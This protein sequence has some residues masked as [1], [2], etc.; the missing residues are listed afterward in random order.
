M[1][2]HLLLLASLLVACG[3][4][5]GGSSSGSGSG[6]G[7][8]GSATSGSSGSSGSLCACPESACGT[9][10]VDLANDP[11]NCGGCGIQCTGPC[12]GTQCLNGT[13]QPP[14]YW[15]CSTGGTGSGSGS[16]TGSSSG[17]G[18]TSSG[19]TTGAGCTHACQS[20]A[21]CAAG[22]TCQPPPFP[23]S[24]TSGGGGYTCQ[25]CEPPG[26]VCNGQ[27][28]HGDQVDNCGACGNACGP[29]QA[30]VHGQCVCKTHDDG[31]GGGCTC[32]NG[33]SLCGDTCS[34]LQ[35]DSAHCGDCQ[36]ACAANQRCVSG[37]CAPPD[38]GA[39]LD[40]FTSEVLQVGLNAPSALLVDVNGD[41]RADLVA[42]S[43]YSRLG[44]GGF[45]PGQL[46]VALSVD[47]GLGSF[48]DLTASTESIAAGDLDGD[49]KV[50]LVA[51]D[52]TNQQLL[53]FF[54]D[55]AGGF[56]PGAS[57]PLPS[58]PEVVRIADFNGDGRPDLFVEGLNYGS[59]SGWPFE[60]EVV[61][62][63][64]S[65]AFGTAVSTQDAVALASVYRGQDGFVGDLNGD[66]KADVAATSGLYLGNGDG[67]FQPPMSLGAGVVTTGADLDGDGLTD[68][69]LVGG[70]D[71]ADG[72]TV[73]ALRVRRGYGDG[74]F[75][76]SEVYA[77]PALPQLATAGRF[78]GG[79]LPDLALVYSG[80]YR[81]ENDALLLLRNDGTGHFALDLQRYDLG[82]AGYPAQG[83]AGDLD[84]NGRDDLAIAQAY[85]GQVVLLRAR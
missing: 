48:L 50:D 5:G 15:N 59:T 34:D 57:V 32:T 36:T 27:C 83:S 80:Y 64:R 73:D 25:P 2:L 1:R 10:C 16:G 71:L 35:T 19:G 14:P 76:P 9:R 21:D 24:T 4:G 39:R 37:R 13:C 55:G 53:L 65:G 28:V 46:R 78:T 68:L 40:L 79:A 82:D 41:G 49:G 67:T 69:V 8:S 12:G 74:G 77:L 43:E 44:D 18:T 61:L 72:C 62:N 58:E 63:Q 60:F 38:A 23:T 3:G 84:G 66:G 52:F 22:Y 56:T 33:Q 30:C 20:S 6:S 70:G 85:V 26:L 42:G 29:F 81:G 54:G 31:C 51:A 45:G 17:S 7:T 11:T 47:G 75:A